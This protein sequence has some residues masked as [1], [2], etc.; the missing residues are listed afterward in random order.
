VA[1]GDPW[2]VKNLLLLLLLLLLLGLS[3]HRAYAD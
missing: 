3:L 1:A 2:S